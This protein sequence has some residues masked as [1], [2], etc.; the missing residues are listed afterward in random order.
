MGDHLVLDVDC[1]VKPGIYSGLDERRSMPPEM[2]AVGKS[3][4]ASSSAV[5]ASDEGMDEEAPLLTTAECR[6]SQDEDDIS[7]MDLPSACSGSLKIIYKFL[8]LTESVFNTGAMKKEI[9]TVKS[10]ISVEHTFV[11][12]LHKNEQ[13]WT[14]PGDVAD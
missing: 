2:L 12:I 1:L 3:S 8:M 5:G 7:N 4:S 11:S 6:I 13:T 14:K 9:S 10:A